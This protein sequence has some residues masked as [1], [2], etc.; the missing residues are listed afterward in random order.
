MNSTSGCSR[1]LGV[2]WFSP[3]STSGSTPTTPTISA[4]SARHRSPSPLNGTTRRFPGGRT[5]QRT[6][7]SWIFST[8]GLLRRGVTL[9]PTRKSAGPVLRSS[10]VRRRLPHRSRSRNSTR[11]L[12]CNISPGSTGPGSASTGVT[13]A[14]SWPVPS[15]ARRR[16]QQRPGGTDSVVDVSGLSPDQQ[17][18]AGLFCGAVRAAAPG[19]SNALG[20]PISPNGLCAGSQYGSTLVA[21][22]Q[23]G[24]DDDDRNPPRIAPRHLF[25]VALGQDNLFHGDKYRME[26]S[27]HRHQRHESGRPVQLP[28]HL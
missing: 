19:P 17:F 28:L 15:P 3:G 1:R 11:P 4:F 6:E 8:D 18:Q 5:H 2:T 21:I 16:L 26:S 9:F 22:M 12:T 10:A 23:P 25:D 20:V 24:T 13:T 14:A 27:A 7:P